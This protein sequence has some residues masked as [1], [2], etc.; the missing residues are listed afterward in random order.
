MFGRVVVGVML[1]IVGIV[2]MP[3]GVLFQLLTLQF[4]ARRYALAV[5]EAISQLLNTTS[6]ELLNATLRHGGVKFGNPDR[7]TSGV[8]GELDA[9]GTLSPVGELI[10]RALDYVDPGHCAKAYDRNK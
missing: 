5:G 9:T 4:K 2:V 7:T 8:L 3:F 6:A 1:G 10:V